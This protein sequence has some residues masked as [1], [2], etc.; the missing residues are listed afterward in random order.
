MAEPEPE[1]KRDA[2][3]H[4]ANMWTLDP[5]EASNCSNLTTKE[6]Q[7][8]WK[9]AKQAERRVRLLFEISNSRIVAQTLSKYVFMQ[10]GLDAETKQQLEEDH[11]RIISDEHWYLDLPE[12]KA[13][14]NLI[15]EEKSFVPCE[16]LIYG[17]M[18]FQG[19]NPEVEKLMA[20]M[21]P[22]NK[23]EEEEDLRQMQTDVTDE[24]MALRYESLIGSIKKKFAKKRQRTSEAEEDLNQNVESNLKRVFLKPQD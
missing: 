9:A 8:N 1:P 5:D 14:E 13:R 7:Q 23:E 10:R 17:R 21:N 3:D 22:K 15:I 4:K 2:G 11:K 18:S 24:E 19:F 20:L 12:L 16:D 6:L